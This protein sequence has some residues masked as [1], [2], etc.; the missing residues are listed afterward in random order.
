MGGTG[1]SRPSAPIGSQVTRGH[2]LLHEPPLL[3]TLPR[4]E[5]E[6]ESFFISNDS[7]RSRREG[8]SLFLIWA[9]LCRLASDQL[10]PSEQPFTAL[11][12][13]LGL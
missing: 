8:D 1:D 12:M 7:I 6:K 4:K 2:I 13:L 3:S 5:L 10:D 9:S 11:A